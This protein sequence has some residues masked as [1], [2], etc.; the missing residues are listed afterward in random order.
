VTAPPDSRVVR[1]ATGY[2]ERIWR[3]DDGSYSLDYQEFAEKSLFRYALYRFQEWSG[4]A[5]F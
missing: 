3:N 1:E 5:T 4:M 2:F